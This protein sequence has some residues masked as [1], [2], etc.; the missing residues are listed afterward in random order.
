MCRC[1]QAERFLVGEDGSTEA[2]LTDIFSALLA[3]DLITTNEAPDA[4]KA[5][6]H[7]RNGDWLGGI[8][9]WLRTQWNIKEP[10]PTFAGLGLNKTHM[11]PPAGFEPALQP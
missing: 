4:I 11:V 10:R 2:E 1:R 9:A 6:G 5:R 3:P 8:P 7:H